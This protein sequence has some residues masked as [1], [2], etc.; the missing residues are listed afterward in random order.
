MLVVGLAVAI[1]EK[2]PATTVEVIKRYPPTPTAMAGE[3]QGN[4]EVVID[5]E[6]EV[7]KPGVYRLAAGSRVSEGLIAAGGL[8]AAADR[9]W[10]AAN[11][12]QAQRLTD[13]MKIYIPNRNNPTSA[14][15]AE[16]QGNIQGVNTKIIS[17][18]SATIEEL[19]TLPGIGPSL[20]QRIL[21]YRQAN[22]GFKKVE[23]IKLVGGIGEKLYERVKD[24]ISL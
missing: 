18:N 17:L 15:A 20:G 22:G 24:K 10:V 8:G 6:G 19:D 21:D 3:T 13:G 5:I 14:K 7:M 1:R 23:E 2:L 11:V 9:E 16:G 4:S 12:N